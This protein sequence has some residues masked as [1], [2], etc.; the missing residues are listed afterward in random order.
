MNSDAG[1]SFAEYYIRTLQQC[2]KED[3]SCSSPKGFL[4]CPNHDDPDL[5]LAV[6]IDP[7]N[8]KLQ[9]H[10]FQGCYEEE[11][12]NSLLK[13][14]EWKEVADA[15]R[16]NKKPTT[17]ESTA[18]R[19][20]VNRNPHYTK[21]PNGTWRFQKQ[22]TFEGQTKVVEGSGDTQEAAKRA[23]YFR[24][25][26]WKSQL[27]DQAENPEL[28]AEEPEPPKDTAAPKQSPFAD[29]YG[30]SMGDLEDAQRIIIAAKR[31]PEKD[32]SAAMKLIEN[33]TLPKGEKQVTVP[34]PPFLKD[35]EVDSYD[36]NITPGTSIRLKD[37]QVESAPL[38][39]V[40]S[41][42][43]AAMKIFG[44]VDPTSQNSLSSEPK[45]YTL[46]EI[47]PVLKLSNKSILK[48][49]KQNK[50]TAYKD[51]HK[52]LVTQANLDAY[53][54]SLQVAEPEPQL[55]PN[56]DIP[57]TAARRKAQRRAALLGGKTTLEKL[58]IFNDANITNPLSKAEKYRK[59]LSN[60]PQDELRA[61]G[62]CQ[63]PSCIG[64]LRPSAGD[65]YF[66]ASRFTLDGP[67]LRAFCT[68]CGI[69]QHISLV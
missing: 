39:E 4:H 67:L 42:E 11:I 16:G 50:L 47:E 17:D 66:F 21:L 32:I 8:N 58:T 30:P 23:A 37:S 36:I 55:Q 26:V 13:G 46:K 62:N 38:P 3:C 31:Y 2:G 60:V 24:I 10:C 44:I 59:G 9:V 48:R 12:V 28:Y 6:K 65:S 43:E 69:E 15:L 34:E 52:Y 25:K 41:K 45:V 7:A 49:I 5:S 14:C 54:K 51:G 27:K 56:K 63:R 68:T 64:L 61:I 33:F 29:Y 53:L 18:Q 35:G 57:L 20:T 22:V 1:K 19:V 40:L